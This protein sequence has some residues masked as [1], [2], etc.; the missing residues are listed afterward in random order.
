[1][2][3][4]KPFSHLYI[5][6][7]ALGYP[8]TER[9]RN[10]FPDASVI[11]ISRYG[12]LFDRPRQSYLEQY[13]SRNL[14]LAVRHGTVIYPGAPVCQSFDQRWFYYCTPAMNCVYNCSYCWLKGM[15]Q[16]ANLV[17][18][19]NQEYFLEETE[20]LLMEHPAYLCLAYETDLVPLEP[21]TGILSQWAQAAISHPDLSIEIRT[22]S[23][24]G[25]IWNTMPVSDR[26]I[27]AFT[28]SP[29]AMIDS[30]EQGTGTMEQ[31]IRT[32]ET[33]A[34]AGFRIR[35]CFDP[36]IRFPGWKAAYEDLIAACRKSI[37]PESIRDCSI[38]TFRISASYLQ[39]MR[40]RF[41]DSAVVQYPYE[42][43]NGYCH[44]PA[45]VKEEMEQ[46]LLSL[47]KGYVSE[48]QIYQEIGL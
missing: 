31:R 43:S 48:K 45:S 8:M 28:F 4:N 2:E 7:E 13:P 42:T 1:M 41:P 39:N 16:T 3:R 25:E 22:K 40:K 44:Y 30:M 23:G 27:P 21:M 14:I 9:I 47:L 6:E 11:R 15:Y 35:L 38:G 29:Q 36:M 24:Y 20:K 5:E 10:C 37:P 18:F 46:Y 12:E 32:A 19:V 17:I 33:A 34:E 26:I